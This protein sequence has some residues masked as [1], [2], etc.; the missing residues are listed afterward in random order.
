MEALAN[1]I[2]DLCVGKKFSVVMGAFISNMMPILDT[3]PDKAISIRSAQYLE[4]TFA[5]YRKG[6]MA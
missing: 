6:K 5:E 3:C 1:E 4:Q 2:R